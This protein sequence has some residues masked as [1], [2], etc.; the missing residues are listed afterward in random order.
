MISN[1]LL[2]FTLRQNC[3]YQTVLGKFAVV[4]ERTRVF[5][6]FK[7]VKSRTRKFAFFSLL[8]NLITRLHVKFLPNLRKTIKTSHFVDD[9]QPL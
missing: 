7:F 1:A 2:N 5:N 8:K 6:I 9:R 4:Y 3:T